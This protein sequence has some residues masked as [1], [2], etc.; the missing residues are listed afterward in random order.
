MDLYHGSTTKF[1][2]LIV[3]APFGCEQKECPTGQQLAMCPTSEIS[4]KFI[5][6]L[7]IVWRHSKMNAIKGTSCGFLRLLESNPRSFADNMC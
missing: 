1:D 6:L 3:V 7:Q 2:D 5:K 4:M